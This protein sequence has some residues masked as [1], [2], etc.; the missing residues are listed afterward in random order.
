MPDLS[1]SLNPS[2]VNRGYEFEAA[3]DRGRSRMRDPKPDSV[4]LLRLFAH[5]DDPSSG[6]MAQ[7]IEPPV[8]DRL[9]AYNSGDRS[10]ILTVRPT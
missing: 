4:A 8:L 10:D 2:E 3:P 6:V 7:G 9:Q 1:S 5:L